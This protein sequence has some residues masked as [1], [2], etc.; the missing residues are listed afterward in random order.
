MRKNA[1]LLMIWA[2]I[3][4]GTIFSC[5][6]SKQQVSLFSYSVCWL[7]LMIEMILNYFDD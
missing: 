2:F 6:I 1:T 3:G 4:L 5:L 7:C